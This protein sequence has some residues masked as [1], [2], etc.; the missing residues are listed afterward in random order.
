MGHTSVGLV[1]VGDSFLQMGLSARGGSG[2]ARLVTVCR[3]AERRKNVDLVIR[4]LAELKDRHP[5][6]YTVVGDGATRAS[7]E[8]LAAELGLGDRVRFTG[9]VSQVE[10]MQQLASADL[11]ILPSSTLPGSHEGFGI[12]Y[13]EANAAGA[14][15]LAARLAGAI[16]AVEEGVS[17][18]FVDEPTVPQIR[19]AIERFLYGEARFDAR[20]C[21]DFASRFTWERVARHFTDCYARV[22]APR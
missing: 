19:A 12:A 13:L 17:G 5:F 10:L 2:P 6:T 3:L 16:E 7:L 1:G 8:G 15:V 11:F 20:R 9:R 18:M 4:A 21:R 22:A 14:P